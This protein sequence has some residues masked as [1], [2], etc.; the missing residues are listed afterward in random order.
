MIV[1]HRGASRVAPEN[2]I[3]AFELAWEQGSDAIEA[4]FHLTSDGQ[5]VCIH[6]SDT[7]RVSG[8]KLVVRESSLG[9]LHR[10]DVGAYHGEKFAGTRLPTMADVLATIPKDK[11]IYVELKTGVEIVNPMLHEIKRS[12]IQKEQVVVIAF[13]AETLRALKA[14]DSAYKTYWLCQFS[15]DHHAEALKPTEASVFETLQRIKADG[16]STNPM[17]S[18]S[19]VA[20]LKDM[21]YTWHVWTVDDLETAKRMMALDVDSI[22]TN[23]PELLVSHLSTHS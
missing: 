1:A 4:D 22:T 12:G 19:F 17:I 11:T 6:D 16:L 21:G 15:I 8:E 5:V 2:T 9:D 14:L 18:P 7:K 23:K 10:L 3:P 20:L 13:N